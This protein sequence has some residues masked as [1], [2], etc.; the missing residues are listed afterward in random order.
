M[1]L[2]RALFSNSLTAVEDE[3]A[4]RPEMTSVTTLGVSRATLVS[5]QF[6]ISN[7]ILTHPSLLLSLSLLQR[8]TEPK[9]HYSNL[10]SL[11][12]V[13]EIA[14]NRLITSA[15]RRAALST[16]LTKAQSNEMKAI[17]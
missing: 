12:N 4:I 2:L 1:K 5:E 13:A 9:Q 3:D 8:N 10:P 14:F 15:K 6:I 7:R 17:G 16:W 11:E